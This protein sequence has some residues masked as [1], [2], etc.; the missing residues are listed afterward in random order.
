MK[1]QQQTNDGG[2]AFP[3]PMV[4]DG[5]HTDSVNERGIT[6][7]EYYAATAL[8]A[9]VS[10]GDTSLL[11]HLAAVDANADA[12]AGLAVSLADTL[13]RTIAERR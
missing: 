7:R 8:N 10:R 3:V 9:L 2:P 12:I 5:T 11:E 1:E 6:K 4:S 13:I